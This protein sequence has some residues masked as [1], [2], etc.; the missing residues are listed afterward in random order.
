MYEKGLIT[1]LGCGLL[2][3]V[4]A[5]PLVLRRVPRNIVYGFRTRATLTSHHLK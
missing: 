4:L 2:L 1:M 3:A 5:V